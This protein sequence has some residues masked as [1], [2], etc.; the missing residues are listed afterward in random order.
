MLDELRARGYRPEAL[1]NHLV[2]IGFAPPGDGITDLDA[3]AAAF[4]PARVAHGGARH[5]A[6]ALDGWQ[7]QA[8][9][10]LDAD[11]LWEWMAAGAPDDAIGLPVDGPVFAAA[12]R[13]NVLFPEDGWGWARRLFDP[14][15]EPDS[16]AR[17]ELAAA[18]PGLFRSALTVHDPAPTDDFGAWA[19]AVGAA[20]GVKGR[21]LYRPLRAALTNAVEGPELGAVV[22]LMPRDL[23]TARLQACAAD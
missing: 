8:L 3:L 6:T 17:A 19:K 12:V 10:R 7:R 11:A 13:P 23:V 16:E 9:D 1:I 15:A 4:D 14:E 5:D 22:P 21:A 20:G 18:G 2:R